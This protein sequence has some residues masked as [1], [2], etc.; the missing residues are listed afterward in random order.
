VERGV[1]GPEAVRTQ[2]REN[3][4]FGAEVIKVCAT[5]GV[6]SRNTDPGAQQMSEAELRAAAEE[7]HMLGMKIAAHA[8][9]APGIKAALRAGIDTIEHASLVDDEGIRLAREKGAFFSMD[10]FNTEY[11]QSEGKK[12]GVDEENLQKDRDVADIQRT[13]FRKA[14][15]A[16]VKMVFGSDAGVMPHATAAGQFR[17]MTQYGMSPMEAIQTATRNA[18]QALNREK[19]VGAIAVGRYGD[20]IAVGG[21]PIANIR[22]LESVDVV[23]KGGQ[24]EKNQP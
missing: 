7:A 17:I 21:D 3:R 5:G 19:D 12:N 9:G 16:G 15:Q 6:F 10:I 8:H 24:V 20:I 22:E 14:H 2:I 23:I 13:N 4:K 11:T 1:N 18:A